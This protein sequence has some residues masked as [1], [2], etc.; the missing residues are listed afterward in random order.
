MK[1]RASRPFRF[2]TVM[3]SG[4]L[5]LW[6]SGAGLAQEIWTGGGAD[7][8]FGT[9]ANW[10]DGSAPAVGSGTILHFTGGTRTTP[11][12]NYNSGDNFGEWWL[13][14]GATAPFTIGG[15]GFGLFNKI[16]NSSSQLFTINT[17]GIF[18]RDGSM[19][20]NPVG[21]NITTGSATNIELDG[22]TTL[23]VFD[24]NNSRTLTINGTLSNGNGTG[25]NGALVTNQTATVILTGTN[26]YGGTVLNNSSTLR[27]GAAGTTGTLGVGNVTLNNTSSLIFDRSNAITVTNAISGAGSVTKLGADTLT[28]QGSNSFSGGVTI[29]AGTV[30]NNTA[31]GVNGLGSGKV[32]IG[33]VAN[34]GA[35]AELLYIGTTGN[36]SFGNLIDVRGNGTA[37]IRVLGFNPTFSGAINL[38]NNL[39]VISNNSFGSTI[40]I[41][42]G[43]TGTGNLVIQ[44]N[45]ANGSNNSAITLSGT[46]VNMVGTITNSGTTTSTTASHTTI[47]AV[48]GTNVTGITQNSTNSNLILTGAN[49]F[50]SNILV[51][52]GTLQA[53]LASAASAAP[54]TGALGNAQALGRTATISTGGTLR[55]GIANVL[56]NGGATPNLTLIANGGTILHAVNNDINSIGPVQLNGGNLS[57]TG[58]GTTAGFKL[59]GTVTV[60]GSALSTISASSVVGSNSLITYNVGDAVV[61]SGNDLNVTAVVADIF[62]AG[63]I[64]KAG[65]G[66]M[67]LTAQN[68]FTGGTRIDNGILALGHA[69]NTL[70]NTGAVNVNGGTLALG[71]N[72][73]TVAAVTLTSGSITGNGAGTL[74]GTSYDVRSGSASAILAGAVALTKSTT[75]TVTLSGANTYSGLTT[76]SGG[77]LTVATTGTINGTSSISIGAGELNYNNSTTALSKGV[78]FSGTGGTLSGTGTISS[79]VTISSGNRQT[80]GSSV[81]TANPTA[82]LGK[83]TF[84]NV[85]GITYS[86]GS[87]FEWNLDSTAVGTRGTN[88]DAVNTAALGGS[89]AIFRVIL[90]SSENFGATFWDF[91]RT[92]AGIFNNIAEN[93]AYDLSTVFSGGFEY[94]NS[95]GTVTGVTTTEGAFTFINGGTDLRWT[96]VP[97]PSSALAGLLLAA[98]LLRRRRSA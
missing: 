79:A 97:E 13:L 15:S 39:T 87:I 56:G 45:A 73:D 7:D 8:N 22:N 88:F 18:A 70:L 29:R 17:A 66:T 63:G 9:N 82:A 68:T 36:N 49:S 12:N 1:P 55:F 53:N 35:A 32:T 85:S 44:S 4:G 48:I 83:E 50:T 74:T 34:T 11:N 47:S 76:I 65:A 69:T 94:Y 90:N 5:S 33:D 43:V 93:S 86:S 42:G 2:S 3:I 20:I 80:A 60:G 81:T 72:T 67:T 96:A 24:G 27:V 37:T 57:S 51:S 61:G 25:G 19:E 78:S 28:L 16:E 54:V 30:F 77:T 71:T 10:F 59:T 91:D 40:G 75:G 84:S 6:F 58:T 14:A 64:I 46:T 23:N 26:D 89:G 21:G 41:S 98:G 31:P 95:T 92:W 38:G 52:A 62:G